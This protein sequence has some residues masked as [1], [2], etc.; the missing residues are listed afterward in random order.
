MT[1]YGA[2]T[3]KSMEDV[4]KE[5]IGEKIKG[6]EC[7]VL[8]VKH[9]KRYYLVLL[10]AEKRADLKAIAEAAGEPKLSFAGE[11]HLFELLNLRPGAVTPLALIYD[12][13]KKVKLITDASLKG[14]RILMHPCVNT[15]TIAMKYEDLLAFVRETGH[16]YMET[17]G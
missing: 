7:K 6:R 16:E 8:F 1:I 10:P 15:K 9:K 3:G 17:E 13:E 5:K 2:F 11:D 14:E 4:E 12:K